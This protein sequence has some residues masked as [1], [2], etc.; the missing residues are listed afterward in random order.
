V[1]RPLVVLNGLRAGGRLDRLHR[2]VSHTG[3]TA[4]Y[5]STIARAKA[6]VIA[7]SRHIRLQLP[8]VPGLPLATMRRRTWTGAAGPEDGSAMPIRLT[9]E[10]QLRQEAMRGR[11]RPR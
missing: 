11:C 7:V 6:A 5:A 8:G 4:Y 9:D 10:E 1:H 3:W 2:F